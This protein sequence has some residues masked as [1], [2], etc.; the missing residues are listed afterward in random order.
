MGSDGALHGEIAHIEGALPDSRRFNA[1]M[2]NEERRAYDNLLIMC[3]YHHTTI[4]DPDTGEKTWPVDRLQRLKR[5]HE[6]IYTSVPD[7]L[8]RQVGDISEGVTY[9]RAV[10]GLAVIGALSLGEDERLQSCEEINQFAERLTQVPEDARSLLAVIVHRGDEVQAHLGAW[11]PEFSIPA[12]ALSSYVDCGVRE[13]RRHIQVL[14][15]CG[16]MVFDDDV[17]EGP[18]VYVVGNSS[19]STGWQLLQEIRRAVNG[20]R[21]TLRRI[22]CDLDFTALDT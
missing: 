15:H 4:D 7:Q 16:L 22:L 1:G 20:D 8:R 17:F 10:N 3:E 2:T 18:P 14:E 21:A 9:V 13:L 19:P 6:A 5:D 11:E 12:D